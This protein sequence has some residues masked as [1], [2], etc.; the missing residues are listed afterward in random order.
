LARVPLKFAWP[1]EKTAKPIGC[2]TILYISLGIKMWRIFLNSIIWGFFD[3]DL[4]M[5]GSCPY[6]Y[7]L[8]YSN[9]ILSVLHPLILKMVV[10]IFLKLSSSIFSQDLMSRKLDAPHSKTEHKGTSIPKSDRWR[11]VHNRSCKDADVR[12]VDVIYVIK[13]LIK[14]SQTLWQIMS[15]IICHV[16]WLYIW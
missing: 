14:N 15:A 3:G 9:P 4:L 1:M 13:I 5:L 12:F 2:C 8:S 10:K 11:P 16:E 6:L 7:F